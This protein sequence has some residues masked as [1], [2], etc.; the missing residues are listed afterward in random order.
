MFFAF[1]T[2]KPLAPQG[3]L[4]VSDV[5]R[6]RCRLSWKPPSDDG[7]LPIQAYIVEAQ[8]LD[9]RK[10][11]KVGKVMGDTQCGVPGL[12]PGKKYKF[13]VKA[14]NAEGESEPLVTATEVLAKDP[15]GKISTLVQSVEL[16][17][18]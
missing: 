11:M 14:V 16:L 6:D 2:D 8:D 4:Q 18:H 5:F 13:C 7:G 1:F 12:E 15:Y 3:P 17:W 10:W 9:N